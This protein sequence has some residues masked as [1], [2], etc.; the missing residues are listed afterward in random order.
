MLIDDPGPCGVCGAAHSTCG[1]AAVITIPQL[2][3]R[4]AAAAAERENAIAVA[5]TLPPGVPVPPDAFT[6]GTYRKRKRS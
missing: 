3:Q 2:S 4:D 1:G 5:A 6:T